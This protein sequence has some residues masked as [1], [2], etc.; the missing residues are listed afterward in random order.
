MIFVQALNRGVQV[1][2]Q[3]SLAIVANHALNPEEGGRSR[4]SRYGRYV[5]KTCSRIQN[6]MTGGQLH[7]VRSV[8]VLHNQF[9]PVVFVRMG[10]KQGCREIRTD[11]MPCPCHLAD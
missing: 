7:S 11:A 1:K 9:S 5:M 3:R 8:R 6:H 10:K 2:E 4:P